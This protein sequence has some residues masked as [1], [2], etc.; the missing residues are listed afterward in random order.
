MKSNNNV[1]FFT[2]GVLRLVV[3]C[4][5][6]YVFFHADSP[7]GNDFREIFMYYREKNGNRTTLGNV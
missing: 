2:P 4:T 3:I 7:H 6:Y 1:I 5:N